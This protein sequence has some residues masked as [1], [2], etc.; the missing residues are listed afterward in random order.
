MMVAPFGDVRNE[1]AA[2]LGQLGIIIDDV[3]VF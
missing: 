1:F 3:A 2:R